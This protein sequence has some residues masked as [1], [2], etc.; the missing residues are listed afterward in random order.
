MWT[1][2]V[3]SKSRSDYAI[4]KKKWLNMSI[5]DFNGPVQAAD[6][7]SISQNEYIEWFVDELITIVQSYQYNIEDEN[8]FKEDITNFIYTLSDTGHHG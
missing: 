6:G 8:K 3:K 5:I 1:N 7:K 2:F 4:T